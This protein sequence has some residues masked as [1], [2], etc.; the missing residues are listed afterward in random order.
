MNGPYPIY[1][2]DDEN[3]QNF[4]MPGDN[5]V[6]P[7]YT[8]PKCDGDGGWYGGVGDTEMIRCDVCRGMGVI[9]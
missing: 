1:G 9:S 6:P 5:P 7:L 2:P 4:P 8:C 3:A